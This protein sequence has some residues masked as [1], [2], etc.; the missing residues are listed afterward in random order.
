MLKNFL[1]MERDGKQNNI[2]DG[3]KIKTKR[4]MVKR[5]K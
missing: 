4:E 3:K 5:W 1:K 2:R